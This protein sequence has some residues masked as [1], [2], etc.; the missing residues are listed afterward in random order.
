MEDFSFL[1]AAVLNRIYSDLKG[2]DYGDFELEY[3]NISVTVN[4]A[5][6]AALLTFSKEVQMQM[7]LEFDDLV[8]CFTSYTEVP[9]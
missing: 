2:M 7:V 9:K 3:A 1:E 4:Y 8:P 6:Q 5:A